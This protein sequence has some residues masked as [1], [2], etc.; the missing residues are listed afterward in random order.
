MKTLLALLLFSVSCHAMTGKVVSIAD[1]DTLTV[2]TSDNEQIKVRFSGIDTPEKNQAYGDK[3]KKALSQKVHG[4]KV[5]LKN[6]SKDG[7]GRT[8]ADVYYSGRWINLEMVKEGWAWH[9]KAYSKD[10]TLAE[11]EVQ[12]RKLRRGL[13]LDQNPIPPWE[14]RNGKTP[15]ASE[16]AITGY[17]LNESSGVR[18]NS[19]CFNY[20]NTKRGRSCKK[21]E[22]RAGGC[23]GG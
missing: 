19:N 6:T 9:Y 10:K 18:H 15:K 22:G 20:E 13:W 7:Y 2:L 14:F 8:L 12:A 17:W 23:C 16:K 5:A 4:R 21:N 1:G 3:A 11:A